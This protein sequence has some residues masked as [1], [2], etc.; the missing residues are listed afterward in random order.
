MPLCVESSRRD[1]AQALAAGG[2]RV[3]ALILDTGSMVRTDPIEWSALVELMSGGDR[4]VPSLQGEV[5]IREVDR[6]IPD[7]ADLAD[8]RPRGEVVEVPA[9]GRY[10][11]E[12]SHL[13]VEASGGLL[14]IGRADGSICLIWG[15]DTTWSEE[16]DGTV[17]ATPRDYGRVGSV[18]SPL[19]RRR[20]LDEW[21]G[22]DFTR[23]V[24]PPVATN[25]LRRPAWQ[26]TLLPPERKGHHHPI[27]DV[28]DAETGLV[29]STRNNGFT[30]VMEWIG[31][32]IGVEIADSRFTC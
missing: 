22:D 32:E 16:P 5:F 1:G 30:S 6:Y 21:R 2:L 18:V 29:L 17:L 7:D 8:W 31:L 27:T 20:E 28:I 15:S 23:P 12:E 14:R 24:S 13:L 9:V 11:V 10:L 4:R 26:V 25:F 3:S 19:V